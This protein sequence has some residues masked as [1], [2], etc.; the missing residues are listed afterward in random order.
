MKVVVAVNLIVLYCYHQ[1][2]SNMLM[3]IRNHEDLYQFY[4]VTKE[5]CLSYAQDGN[6]VC[7]D[8][9]ALFKLL[10]SSTPELLNLVS[11]PAML[12]FIEWSRQTPSISSDVK[13]A[14]SIITP[15]RC[16]NFLKNDVHAFKHSSETCKGIL[17]ALKLLQKLQMIMFAEK[18]MLNDTNDPDSESVVWKPLDTAIAI[19]FLNSL[20]ANQVT[21]L[22]RINSYT[23]RSH[24]SSQNGMLHQP[25]M[26]I[27]SQY[28]DQ[29]PSLKDQQIRQQLEQQQ[30]SPIQSQLL[31]QHHQQQQGQ[32]QE[33]QPPSKEKPFHQHQQQQ[34][35]HQQH[36]EQQQDLL[37]DHNDEKPAKLTS[38]LL[39][40]SSGQQALSERLIL[41]HPQKQQAPLPSTALALHHS[42][43]Q[44][45]QQDL[46]QDSQKQQ[47][48]QQHH[49]QQQQQQQQQ[50]QEEEKKKKQKKQSATPAHSLLLLPPPPAPPAPPA[51]TTTPPLPTSRLLPHQQQQRQ[52]RQYHL[53]PDH[54]NQHQQALPVRSPPPP[55]SPP[56]P[57][58]Q[59]QQ[60]KHPQYPRQQCLQQMHPNLQQLQNYPNGS[61]TP[62]YYQNYFYDS[63]A[64]F[65]QGIPEINQ[66]L[67]HLTVQN[68]KLK[69]QDTILMQQINN[70][71]QIVTSLQKT[72]TSISLTNS[73]STKGKVTKLKQSTATT[74]ICSKF[75]YD[76][77]ISGVTSVSGHM[78]YSET[79]V[80]N[81]GDQELVNPLLESYESFIVKNDPRSN[82]KTAESSHQAP[83][84]AQ[85]DRGELPFQSENIFEVQ[86]DDE[87]SILSYH[88][89]TFADSATSYSNILPR[90]MPPSGTVS[91]PLKRGRMATLMSSA[92]PQDSTSSTIC[93]SNSTSNIHNNAKEGQLVSSE[94]ASNTN[95]LS[96]STEHKLKK[97][98]SRYKESSGSKLSKGVQYQPPLT[99]E[100][101]RYMLG[102]DGKFS[103]VMSSDQ[104]SI[105]SIYNEFYQSL[106]LQVD[107]FV[108][109]YGKSKL[110]QFRKKRTFQ[111]KKA[112]VYLVEKISYF[113]K[114]PPEQVL[115][116]VDDVRIKEGKSVVWVCNN[117][118]SLK[119]A[120]VK[121][122]PKLKDIIM[123]YND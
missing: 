49:H 95:N 94:V 120:L 16:L 27:H 30:Q 97:L 37:H 1:M 113:S 35:Q 48:Q 64:L 10:M 59:Q 89:I 91:I 22:G 61:T 117:L 34:Q 57:L 43:P 19:Q 14:R 66:R 102:E 60:L 47:Q 108:Q 86:K 39:E 72:V 40:Q 38:Q 73:V 81:T 23:G 82:T 107:S 18:P 63:V 116:I 99:S 9:D 76:S 105:Y 79:N 109:D 45:Q 77:N 29:E 70:L 110:T 3:R 71:R 122:R 13:K 93:Y 11:L 96:S 104:D 98:R 52:Q 75:T 69:Q 121:Y 8:V 112:F 62:C 2:L 84:T 53:Q 44:P 56:L 32:D 36:Q 55:P 31:L 80:S 25:V 6:N 28:Q 17:G 106:K 12:R 103:I 92:L 41:P 83:V 15:T 21:P 101:K 33:R 74:P 5:Q 58:P 54:Q 65:Q 87:G 51:T 119:Y 118:G 46:Q 24:G 50:E 114:L 20:P 100:G 67:H 115:D 42:E 123:G 26:Q 78:N 4:T 68:N 90:S 85:K 111:K 88:P 7:I